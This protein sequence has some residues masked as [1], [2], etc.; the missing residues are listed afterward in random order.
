MAE[1]VQNENRTATNSRRLTRK[2]LWKVFWYSIAIESGCSTTKQE[3]P[4]FT[5]AMIPVVEK[6]CTT[7]EEK[8]EAYTRHT[9]LFLTE[10]RMAQFCVGV[11]AAMEER[12][13][14]EKDIDPDSIN[15]VKVALM[16][17]LAGIGDS[18]IHGT[19]R[20]IMAGIACSLAAASAY[21]SLA[22]PLLFLAVMLTVVMVVRYFGIFR[23]YSSGLALVANMQE[24]GMLDKL[25]KYAAIAAFLVC[26]G[27]ISSL[28]YC[29]TPIT[30]ATEETTI[31][32]QEVLDGLMPGVIPLLYTL[33]MYFLLAKKK[34]QPVLLMVG[35]MVLGIACVYLG[36]LG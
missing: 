15:A 28:V 13:A 19:L 17:P 4:G 27:F 31:A 24:G 23:G 25:T 22:G 9:Q 12:L 5:Q 8:A 21:R 3:A 11:S 26:G 33:L 20:P 6:V 32:L 16:G 29:Y 30:Y 14:L 10:G 2:D 36:I 1:S 18:L 35:T 34:V 7:K